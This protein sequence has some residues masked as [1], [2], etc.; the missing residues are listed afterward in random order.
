MSQWLSWSLAC[1]LTLQ[2]G[3]VPASPN[4]CIYL[5]RQDQI[6]GGRFSPSVCLSF[7]CHVTDEDVSL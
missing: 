1:M 4:L 7:I 6:R 3:K 2:S 5:D